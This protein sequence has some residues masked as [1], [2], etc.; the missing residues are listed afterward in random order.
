MENLFLR[1][2]NK[3]IFMNRFFGDFFHFYAI[4]PFQ[5]FGGFSFEMF[6]VECL[7]FSEKERKTCLLLN[8]SI[9]LKDTL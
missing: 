6:F 3:L 7:E 5:T 1:N 8:Y 4:A 2:G 9:F